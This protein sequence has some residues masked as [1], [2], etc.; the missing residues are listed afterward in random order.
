MSELGSKICPLLIYLSSFP[1]L[2]LPDR[3]LLLLVY[4]SQAPADIDGHYGLDGVLQFSEWASWRYLT[5]I[6]P[7]SHGSF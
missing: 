1:K 2:S 5:S 6:P 7:Q 4:L 3:L